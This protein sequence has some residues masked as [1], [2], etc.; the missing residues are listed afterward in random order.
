MTSEGHQKFGD[1]SAFKR[2]DAPH[3]QVHASGVEAMKLFAQG[4]KQ[5]CIQKLNQMEQASSEVMSLLDD[6]ARQA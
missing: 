2:L 4:N 5:G 6:L 1:L 3:K